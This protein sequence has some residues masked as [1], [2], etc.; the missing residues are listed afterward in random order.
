MFEFNE[1]GG[2]ELIGGDGAVW[3]DQADSTIDDSDHFLQFVMAAVAVVQT[4][5]QN[6]SARNSRRRISALMQ[7]ALAAMSPEAIAELQKGFQTNILAAGNPI[8]QQQIQDLRSSQ[9][10]RGLLESGFGLAQEQGLRGQQQNAALQQ[11]FSQAQQQGQ[12]NA[13]AILGTIPAIAN[14]PSN[15]SFINNLSG[16]SGAFGQGTGLANAIGAAGINKDQRQLGQQGQFQ[17]IFPP[18]GQFN[19]GFGVP[20]VP[21][22][23][24]PFSVTG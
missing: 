17:Q 4:I 14:S 12:A 10:Q 20:Q 24:N 21:T 18:G 19:S 16:I 3:V 22:P 11:S 6:K 13:N 7:Q 1:I 8:F 15:A 9:G 23:R 2:P 5:Q